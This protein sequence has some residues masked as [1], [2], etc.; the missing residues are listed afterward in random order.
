M[1]SRLASAVSI[2]AGP[3][4]GFDGIYAGQ[5]AQDRE[6]ILLEILGATRPVE[7][8]SGLLAPQ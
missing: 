5:R 1:I 4:A 8:A 7:I 6:L 2:A 3:F